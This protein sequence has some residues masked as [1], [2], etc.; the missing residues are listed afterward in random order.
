MNILMIVTSHDKLGET[1]RKTGFWLEEL[2]APYYVFLDA[3]A[4]VTLATPKGG[5]PPMDPGSAE[6]QF[7]TSA[8][9]RFLGDSEAMARLDA[10]VPLTSVR[11]EDYDALFFP[12]GHGPLWDL[13][14]D[15]QSIAL[16][17]KTIASG[18]PVGAVCHGP[19]ALMRAKMPNDSPLVAGLAVTGFTNSEEQAVGL[20]KV[21]PFSIEDEFIRLGGRF[22]RGGDFAPH[23]VQDGLVVTGQNPASSEAAAHKL[24]DLLS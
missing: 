2:A 10:T 1:G 9:R 14:N 5:R 21:V 15:I 23:A 7:Q 24:L 6:I 11:G 20:E 13:A 17:E 18:K 22:E 12:G 16:I 19:A 4:R 3:G 8:T